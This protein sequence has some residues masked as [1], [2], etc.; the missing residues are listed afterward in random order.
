[1]VEYGEGIADR[2]GPTILAVIY[3]AIYSVITFGN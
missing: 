1:M 3:Q 2:E